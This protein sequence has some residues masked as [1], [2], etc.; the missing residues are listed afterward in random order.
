MRYVSKAPKESVFFA[1]GGYDLDIGLWDERG[2]EEL[3]AIVQIPKETYQTWVENDYVTDSERAIGGGPL[4]YNLRTFV[5]RS[6]AFEYEG[7]MRKPRFIR[8]VIKVW[9]TMAKDIPS[10]VWGIIGAIVTFL[11]LNWLGISS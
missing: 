6:E 9:R 10:F 11:I 5:L 8:N 7:W 1:P 4:S 3:E 2:I